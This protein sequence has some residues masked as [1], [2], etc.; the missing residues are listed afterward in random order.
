M[1][2]LILSLCDYTG[3]WSRPYEEAGY[4]V[5]RVDL[6]HG[7]DVRLLRRIEEPIHGI[8]A[9]PP[10]THFSRAG[11]SHWR[12]KGEPAIL[13]GLAI[14]DAC[15]R[16]VAIYRPTWWALENP[17]G[18]LK[19][20]LGPPHWRFDP[21]MFG[22]P[23]TKRTWL[24]GHFTP[25]VPLV[26]AQARQSVEPRFSAPG[27]LGMHRNRGVEPKPSAKQ[28]DRMTYLGSRRKVERSATPR[29]FAT[30]FFQANP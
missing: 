22:D 1:K 7:Q 29:G 20:Y 8:L 17:I 3:N 18:R 30:A 13:E 9:A 24:W 16:M 15:L 11:A 26:S 6:Q 12:R 23:W 28:Y 27:E 5:T 19:D 2:G 10:C 21:W 4:P 14:V 25:P